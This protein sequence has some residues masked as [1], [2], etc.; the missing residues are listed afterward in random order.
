MPVIPALR[1][2]RQEDC[3]FNTSMGYIERPRLKMHR[4]KTKHAWSFTDQALPLLK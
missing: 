2:L 3:E 4:N 1:R